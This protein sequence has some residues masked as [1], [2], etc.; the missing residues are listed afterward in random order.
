MAFDDSLNIDARIDQSGVE[1]GMNDMSENV[2]RGMEAVNSSFSSGVDWLKKLKEAAVV[3]GAVKIFDSM[4]KSG[5][6]FNQA[7]NSK[8]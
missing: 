3:A 7:R 5:D 4:L 2:R 1:S 6:E 8:T